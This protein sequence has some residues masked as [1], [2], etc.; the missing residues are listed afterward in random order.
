MLNAVRL[1]TPLSV[2][3]IPS[4][5]RC[6]LYKS[7]ESPPPLDAFFD[8]WSW[9]ESDNSAVFFFPIFCFLGHTRAYPGTSNLGNSLV[10]EQQPASF[11]PA[12]C[13]LLIPPMTFQVV[14]RA[15]VPGLPPTDLLCT[16]ACLPRCLPQRSPLPLPSKHEVGLHQT[17]YREWGV[18]CRW[19]EMREY[20]DVSHA[21]HLVRRETLSV[22]LHQDIW[23]HQRRK[24]SHR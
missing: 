14:L 6:Q 17:L 11:H 13:C 24:S 20:Y 3:L 5:Y 19:P 21:T 1:E 23:R 22:W 2:T 7:P 10:S 4:Q 8:V 12:S 16:V 15:R 9:N 18:Q